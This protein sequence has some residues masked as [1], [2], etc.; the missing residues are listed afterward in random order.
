MSIQTRDTKSFIANLSRVK[1]IL[2]ET[3]DIRVALDIRDAAVAANAYARAKSSDEIAQLAMDIKLRAERKAGG[4]L[5]EMK[6]QGMLKRGGNQAKSRDVTLSTL[7]IS[8]MESKR[9]QLIASIPDEKFED[10]MSDVGRLT[11][12]F[13][14]RMARGAHVGHS[15]GLY[16][17]Y[18]PR[19]IIEAARKLMKT[20]DVDPA[21]SDIAN[22]I[23][24]ATTYYT[25][26][27]NGLLQEWKGNIWMNPPYSQ[28]LIT[29]F[30]D[31]LVEKYILGE[32]KQA[33][34]LVNNA[35]ETNFYQNMMNH[36]KAICFIKGRVKFIDEK[37]ESGGA[38]LQGQTILYFGDNVAEFISIFSEFGVVLIAR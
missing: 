38:P 13:L 30:C 31:L 21:S 1:E 29:Q 20:I 36:S 2:A 26:E 4:F 8:K 18:T 9:W 14:L 35:T 10:L 25:I 11:Q 7:D 33:C 32:V 28:P 17:W 27:N 12:G 3:G 15:T 6:D 37:G 23:I 34:V 16:E 22:Q 19:N 5:H 24:G